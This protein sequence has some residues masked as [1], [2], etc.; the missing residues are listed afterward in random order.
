MTVDRLPRWF[1][2]ALFLAALAAALWRIPTPEAV[3]FLPPALSAD[4]ATRESNAA[5][6][7][8]P[9][10]KGA[11]AQASLTRWPD[12]RLALAWNGPSRLDPAENAIWVSTRDR[13]GQWSTP[14]EVATRATAAGGSF[15]HVRSI[16]SPTLH[17]EGSWLQLWYVGQALGEWGG[18]F[19]YHSTSTDAG[20]TWTLARR[21]PISAGSNLSQFSLRPALPLADGGIALP[22]VRN[23][24]G[25]PERWLRFSATGRLIDQIEIRKDDPLFGQAGS[26]QVEIPR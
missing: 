3:N 21:L 2:P 1:P 8:L 14:L 17:A 16:S 26:R 5:Q 6:A 10:A 12:G 25:H 7:F 23:A 19:L 4:V 9:Q 22:L 18:T 11:H 13:Q 24:A 20:K 15:A